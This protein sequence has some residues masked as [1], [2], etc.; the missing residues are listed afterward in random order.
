MEQ[1]ATVEV[2]VLPGHRGDALED[3]G[4]CRLGSAG[5]GRGAESRGPLPAGENQDLAQ[6][7]YAGQLG[8]RAWR[9]GPGGHFVGGRWP[10][11][12]GTVVLL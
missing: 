10:R 8:G 3:F 4:G 1:V 2:D 5:A 6:S 9:R 11:T 12:C 7:G